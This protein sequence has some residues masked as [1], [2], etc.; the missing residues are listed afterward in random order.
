MRARAGLTRRGWWLLAAALLLGAAAYLFGLDELYPLGA[1]SL[2]LVVAARAWVANA[3]WDLRV[4]R[5]IRPSR[6]PEGT[7]ARVL[8]SARNHGRKRSPVVVV[9]D[10]FEGGR[11]AASFAVAPLEPEESRG[12]TYRLPAARRG[13][14][15]LRSLEVEIS[16]PFGLARMTRVGAP[17]GSLTVHPRVEPLAQSSI[18][19]DSDRDRRVPLPV[20]G[21]GGD[22]FYGLREYEVGDDLRHVHWASTA[23]VDEIM[24][25]QPENFWRGRTTIAVDRRPGAHSSQTFEA[26]LSA[27]ASLATS[28]LRSGMQTR[29]VLTGGTDTGYGSGPGHEAAILDT[30]AVCQLKE[31]SGL[32]EEFRFAMLSGPIVL[33]T[34]DA[35]GIAEVGAVLRKAGR[36]SAA[37]VVFLRAGAKGLLAPGPAPWGSVLGSP[38]GSPLPSSGLRWRQVVVPPGVSFRSA[39]GSS[40]R[41]GVPC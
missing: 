12:A 37:V 39:W 7:E 24:I 10:R 32:W 8:V 15:R 6:L 41:L 26:A 40:R 30:L 14:Y 28:T 4:A 13:L 16:D 18:P 9:R 35:A 23:R 2:V 34:T 27:A 1:G 33:L 3:T 5:T 20:L 29:L 36:S 19:S 11:M 38:S 22:E 25:R 17:G 21:R 31:G